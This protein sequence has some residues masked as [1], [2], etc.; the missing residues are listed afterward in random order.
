MRT[1]RTRRLATRAACAFPLLYAAAFTYRYGYSPLVVA[2]HVVEVALT[3]V[4]LFVVF[5]GL[6]SALGEKHAAVARL[7]IA[8]AGATMTSLYLLVLVVSTVT[9]EAWGWSVSIDLARTY[10][11]YLPSIVGNLPVSTGLIALGIAALVAALFGIYFIWWRVAPRMIA[12]MR[13]SPPRT[14][15]TTA[16][17]VLLGAFILVARR[18]PA[19]AAEPLTALFTAPGEA[20]AEQA[21]ASNARARH[22]YP[23]TQSFSHRNIILIFSDALRADHMG[24]YGYE[25]ATTPFLSHLDSTGHLRKVRLAMATCPFSACGLLSTLASRDSAV[26]ELGSLKL[27]DIL[28]DRGYR[29]NFIGS[30][31]HTVWYMLRVHYGDAVDYF[32]DGFHSKRYALKDDRLVLE[33]LEGVPPA[34]GTPAFFWFF[35]SAT[36][37]V[38]T[39][40]PEFRRWLPAEV[41]V[42]SDATQPQ[43][44]AYDNGILQADNSMRQ[45]LAA[46]DQKGYLAGSIVVILGDHGD[47]FG[48][49]GFFGHTRYLYQEMLH[50]PLLFYDD[51]AA[52]YA[53]LDFA[54]QSDIAPTILERLGLPQ[55]SSWQGQSL[56]SKPA[57]QFSTHWTDRGRPW[58]AVLYRDRGRIYKYMYVIRWGRRAEELYEL[59]VDP[60]ERKN[61]IAAAGL[62]SARAMVRGR[63][64]AR[65]PDDFRR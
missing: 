46:L 23:G 1:D 37:P 62:D 3:C 15:L 18:S 14:L 33:G 21:R 61:V 50:I 13:R 44:N 7:V 56:L 57:K 48:E 42:G 32:F 11:Q 41:S 53:N 19:A 10:L 2:L 4:V 38:G 58:H 40:L 6:A 24:V 9:N 25:R 45:I 22:D 31:D 52:T 26:L 49:H 60:G 47:G 64:A 54:T 63:A 51:S 30:S 43:R 59:S 27:Y 29:V 17:V 8:L 28:H 35:L 12:A 34:N 5:R 20:N 36:H 65:W 39:K 55:P 16:L